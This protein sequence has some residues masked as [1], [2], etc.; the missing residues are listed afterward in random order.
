VPS[1]IGSTCVDAEAPDAVPDN[2]P[3]VVEDVEVVVDVL[4]DMVVVVKSP[5]SFAV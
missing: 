3:A 5:G 1:A 2:D 4:L